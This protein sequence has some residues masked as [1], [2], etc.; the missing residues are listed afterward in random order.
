M[1]A[2]TFTRGAEFILDASTHVPA[3][4]GSGDEVLWAEGEPLLIAAPAGVGKTTVAG[5]LALARC[6][7]TPSP[8]V[9]GLPVE[10]DFE[11][12]TAYIAADRP[13]QAARSMR[14]MV[15]AVQRPALTSLLV[16]EG[17]LPF[18]LV[19]D[20]AEL[21]GWLRLHE[22]GT[23]LIDSLKD[24]AVGVADDQVGAAVGQAL[25]HVVAA[26]IEVVVLHH[27]RK[28]QD[29][30]RQPRSLDDVYGSTWITASAGSVLLLW[31]KA[32]DAV[33]ELRHLKQPAGEV[34]PLEVVHDHLT[35]KSTVTE[36][37]TA[38]E[39]VRGATDG[40]VTVAEVAQ[41]LYGATPSREQV[42]KARRKLDSLV[43]R[44]QAVK[45]PGDGSKAAS[46]YRPVLHRRDALASENAGER[47]QR[48]THRDRSRD[49]SRPSRNGS[50]E[51]H[52]PNTDD[53]AQRSEGPPSI[54]GAPTVNGWTEE[55]AGEFIA[56]AKASSPE[57]TEIGTT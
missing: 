12:Y 37:V 50:V 48:D 6:G 31:G 56:K 43:T 5:Q 47:D 16:W 38:W 14:R 44:E 46:R 54:G 34:G 51:H 33:V 15:K 52:A 41:R 40:G 3:V 24:I 2:R 21:A 45:V 11:R 13:R 18:S 36:Q 29:G 23:V 30:N 17:P 39:I 53:H 32:G 27:Q 8:N 9:L 20:P 57:A 55:A 25:Q 22:V 26:G 28:S 19:R 10:P 1:T 42:E 4:W 35:G 7:A 49:L